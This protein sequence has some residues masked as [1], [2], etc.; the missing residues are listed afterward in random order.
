MSVD[1]STNKR[2]VLQHICV[3]NI[4]TNLSTDT[5]YVLHYCTFTKTYIHQ[6]L[7][8]QCD[9]YQKT[10]INS[11][12]LPSTQPASPLLLFEQCRKIWPGITSRDMPLQNPQIE[13]S[14]LA[15]LRILPGILSPTKYLHMQS[16]ELCLA[17]SEIL[18]PTHLPAECVNI[19]EDARH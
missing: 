16:T 12:F 8:Y 13:S 1:R 5:E 7:F 10:I 18:T 17:S 11:S 15:H 14:E 2:T 6:I 4:K 9:F 19:L 3:L